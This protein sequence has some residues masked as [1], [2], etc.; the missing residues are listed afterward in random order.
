MNV[1]VVAIIKSKLFTC[2]N[3]YIVAL[4]PEASTLREH[5]AVLW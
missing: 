1:E 4:W 2:R 5:S 3:T